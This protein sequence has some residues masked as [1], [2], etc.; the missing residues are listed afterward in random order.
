[1]VKGSRGS[2]QYMAP[3][4]LLQHRHALY[5]AQLSGSSELDDSYELDGQASDLFALGLVAYQFLTECFPFPQLM[6]PQE[7]HQFLMLDNCS[8]IGILAGSYQ[9]WTVGLFCFIFCLTGRVL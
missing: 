8:Q 5:T 6:T 1:M 2:L 3:E 4:E 7:Y 9:D